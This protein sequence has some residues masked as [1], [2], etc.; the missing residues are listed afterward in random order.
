MEINSKDQSLNRPSD[1]QMD[2]RHFN[3]DRASSLKSSVVFLNGS[4][5]LLEY[6]ANKKIDI[7]TKLNTKHLQ[8]ALQTA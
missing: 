7:D 5:G 4:T 3:L 1:G 8:G 2:T 6:A